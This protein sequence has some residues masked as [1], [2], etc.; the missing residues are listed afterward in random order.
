MVLSLSYK[1]LVV[2]EVKESPEL[3]GYSALSN[4]GGALGLYLGGSLIACCEVFEILV[5]LIMLACGKTTVVE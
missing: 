4:I 2:T 1:E 3:S 5:R